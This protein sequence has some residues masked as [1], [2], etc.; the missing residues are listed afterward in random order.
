MCLE[1]QSLRVHHLPRKPRTCYKVVG[2]DF[3]NRM[4]SPIFFNTEFNLG[5]TKTDLANGEIRTPFEK[6]YKKGFHVFA[7]KKSAVRYQEFRRKWRRKTSTTVILRC[8]CENFT[9]VGETWV[10]FPPNVECEYL[11]TLVARTLTPICIE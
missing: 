4:H 8:V 7:D 2:V 6:T 1:G 9:A 10:S 11:P 5:I 3:R